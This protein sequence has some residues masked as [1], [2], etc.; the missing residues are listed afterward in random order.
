MLIALAIFGMI[1]AADV[2][3]LTL[4]FTEKVTT[5]KSSRRRFD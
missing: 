1:T 3:L 5:Q 2:A 4:T